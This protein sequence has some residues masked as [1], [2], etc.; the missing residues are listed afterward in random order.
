MTITTIHICPICGGKL[1]RGLSRR[2]DQ[3]HRLHT[4]RQRIVHQVVL[5]CTD[6]PF[7]RAV[8]PANPAECGA[9]GG[10]GHLPLLRD[11]VQNY[12]RA[13]REGAP[14]LA[15]EKARLVVEGGRIHA[16]GGYNALVTWL[17]E[18]HI[19]ESTWYRWRKKYR[20]QGVEGL[21]PQNK[22]YKNKFRYSPASPKAGAGLKPEEVV[23]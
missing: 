19:A 22:G 10:A 17:K 9:N 7:I 16:R 11:L 6:C 21:M 18:N 13:Q 12:S 1:K 14:P 5:A 8:S 15:G 4:G 20:E 3:L 2:H 23:R